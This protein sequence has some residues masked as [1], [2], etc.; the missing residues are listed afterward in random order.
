MYKKK[1]V[2]FYC[3]SRAPH[4][5]R[6][7]QVGRSV[8]SVRGSFNKKKRIPGLRYCSAPENDYY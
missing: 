8:K 3:V 4:R 6:N 5:A 1:T 2:V 7:Q